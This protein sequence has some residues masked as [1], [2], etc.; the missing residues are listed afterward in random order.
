MCG[1]IGYVGKDNA[2]KVLLSGLQKLEYRGY[3][4]AGISVRNHDGEIALVKSEGKISNL[5]EKVSK[6][7]FQASCGIGHSRWSTHGKP[8]E[9]NAHPHYSDG[10]N[11]V[12]VHNGIIENYQ[13]LK[14]KL[15]R[16][17]YSFYSETDT[18]I[19]IKLIDYYYKK[20]NIGPID[21]INKALVRARGSYALA[22]MFKDYPDQVWF[23]KK[24][25]PLI[26]A[27]GEKECY[28]A[29]DIPALLNYTNQVYYVEDYECGCINQDEIKFFDLNGD[30][31]TSTKKIVTIDWQADSTNKGIYPFYMIKE[32]HEQP[33]AIEETIYAYLDE[34]KN[35]D[36]SKIGLEE[37]YLKTLDEIYIYAC[38]SAYHAGVV[39]QYVIE[40]ITGINA[41]VELA[42]EFKY[43]NYRMNKN[44]L[45][46]IIS[47]SGETK[48][49]Y[50][51]LLKAK[52]SNIKTLAIC[53]VKGS[54]I[55]RDADFTA[56]TYA[57]PEIAVATTKAY[58][59]QLVV[60]Y[61]L[62]LKVAKA[63]GQINE[64]EYKTLIEDIL[65]IKE[66]VEDILKNEPSIQLLAQR[67]INK[68]DVFFIGRGIDY[69]LCMEGS[70]KLKEITYI[71][72]DSYAAGELKHGTLSLIEQ[73]IAVIAVITQ[74]DLYE[75]S[76]SNM[77]EVKS[78]GASI[79]SLTTDD[80]DVQDSSKYQIYIPK[81]NPLFT[82]SLSIIPLQ[83]LAYYTSIGKGIDPDKPKNLAKSVT[84]E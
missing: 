55:T 28:L 54:T 41:R 84:V 31:I 58:S 44:S 36:F 27:K 73:G 53:N 65:S 39:G 78:R 34:D 10:Y 30:D 8:S 24:G 83:L 6:I 18:E 23:A 26:I 52:K 74:P 76:I 33:N 40:K 56:L 62:S 67:L 45:A 21:A 16:N 57:G 17:N 79:I 2:T 20:Y 69:A 4:S 13:E 50:E 14:E 82:P 71:H 25:S 12:G 35:I 29:S 61:F 81:I 43:R 19:I 59:C 68:K 46:I 64:E 75:K 15:L 37:E 3:D 66:K 77:V 80:L 11:V 42:S 51:A 63:K 7:N 38:G 9:V 1:I 48:D 60:L 5:I 49:T 32:I 70:L 72:S 47:Q 22:L